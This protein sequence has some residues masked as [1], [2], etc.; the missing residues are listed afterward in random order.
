MK[1]QHILTLTFFLACICVALGATFP[2]R[3]SISST[4]ASAAR[5]L[6]LAHLALTTNITD[7]FTPCSI[8]TAVMPQLTGFLEKNT[9]SALFDVPCLSDINLQHIKIQR[10]FIF[11][12]PSR[13]SNWLLLHD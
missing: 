1:Q 5:E 9:C 8:C 2:A 11:L 7:G 10:R 12:P 4:E 13:A 3:R 6:V